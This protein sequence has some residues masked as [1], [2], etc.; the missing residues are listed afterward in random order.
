MCKS[1]LFFGFLFP[2]RTE[3]PC[4]VRPFQ[5]SPTTANYLPSVP[6]SFSPHQTSFSSSLG[7]ILKQH[8]NKIWN[9]ICRVHG[10]LLWVESNRPGPCSEH[11]RLAL[12]LWLCLRHTT[13]NWDLDRTTDCN[14]T[15][16]LLALLPNGTLQWNEAGP[17]KYLGPLFIS[18]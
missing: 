1:L 7:H 6:W 3:C 2:L 8:R 4:S 17:V 14:M 18:L 5:S 16:R 12:C 11:C 15:Q 10:M 9:I 13:S